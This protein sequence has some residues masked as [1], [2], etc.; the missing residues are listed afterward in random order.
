MF[1][2]TERLLLRPAWPEDWDQ[3]LDG[4]ADEGVVMN[5]A[6][7]P[8]PYS[9]AD[10]R[11]WTAQP[12]DQRFPNFL[13]V[14]SST[15]RVIGSIG[16]ATDGDAAEFG[17]WLARSAWGKGYATEAGRGVLRVARALGH[18]WIRAGHFIDNPNSGKVL[19]KLGFR[20]TGKERLRESKARG[21]EVRSIEF[22][23]DLCEVAT[24]PCMQA[25]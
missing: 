3:V 13:I 23:L 12:Q 22:T 7:A 21:H 14:E 16:L 20:P 17:Y 1:H 5:L 15:G 11:W 6:R 10:A 24:M 2:V 19:R 4:I 18:R 8:W 25:A 9:E